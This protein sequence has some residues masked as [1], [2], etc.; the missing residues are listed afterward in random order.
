MRTGPVSPVQPTSLFASIGQRAD[1][2]A[3]S[4]IAAPIR[5]SDEAVFG[6][7]P[8]GELT[9]AM[10]DASDPTD[11][12]MVFSA[13]LRNMGA[14]APAHRA[15]L[16]AGSG[17][18]SIVKP[19]STRGISSVLPS[20]TK[21][22]FDYY[23]R[24]DLYQLQQHR[25]PTILSSGS[26]DETIFG[27]PDSLK[28]CIR[29]SLEQNWYGYSDSLG[30]SST[31][32][33][34]A[35]LESSRFTDGTGIEKA[36]VAVTL[37]GTAAVSALVDLLATASNT[38]TDGALVCVPNYPPLTATIARRLPV[39]LV[40]TRLKNGGVDIA[41]LIAAL[42]G[43]P[44]VV[45]L[46][47]VTNPWGRRIDEQQ[48]REL[49]SALPDDCYLLL[50]ECHD[51]FGPTVPLSPARRHPRVVSIRSLSK[52]WAAPG[53]KAG[54]IVG[55]TA[56]IDEFYGYASTAYGGPPSILYLFLEMFALFEH[57]R[58]TGDHALREERS[59]LREIYGLT[60]DRSEAGLMN[61]LQA[62]EQMA[63][64]VLRRRRYTLERLVDGGIPVLAPD[65]SIN[66]FARIGKLPSYDLYRHLI[67]KTGVSVYPGVLCMSNTRGTA[68]ISPNVPEEAL[69]SA[70]DRI[71]SWHRQ[72]PS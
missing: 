28:E 33:A 66:I 22:V 64:D 36:N 57:A 29:F 14:A 61:Y 71:L 62:A 48:L 27:L 5:G 58:L 31:R 46:Q 35:R 2:V 9:V 8:L 56:L 67:E 10:N 45:L 17:C 19:P 37:G 50:D 63:Q 60:P 59:Y 11:P 21:M 26:S 43:R 65:Y 47:T 6:G 38:T 20:V 15:A 30:R 55:S 4:P 69:Q 34:L 49:I 13:F 24:D 52:Q 51:A 7:D 39:T 53:L 54:W 32:H 44:R 40:N 3:A 25:Q 68:R 23:F 41:D 18:G 42:S 16:L 70:L 12:T 1:I 72:Q